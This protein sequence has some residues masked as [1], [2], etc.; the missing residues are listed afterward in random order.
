MSIKKAFLIV[1][2]VFTFL[3]PTL[4]RFQEEEPTILEPVIVEATRIRTDCP[5]GLVPCGT[6]TC[7]C[8]F[9]DFFVMLER[10][11][12]FILFKIV[13]PLA[14]LMLVVAG[15]MFLFSGGNPNTIARAKSLATAVIIGLAIIY[16]GWLL[17][18]LFL[19]AIGLSKFGMGLVG[20]DKWFIIECP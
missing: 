7:P 19:T 1:F 5:E 10:I 14:I 12:D 2:I 15:A 16:G 20:P 18:S 17:I 6:P 8:R 3:I 13:P 11:V 9:C 4:A